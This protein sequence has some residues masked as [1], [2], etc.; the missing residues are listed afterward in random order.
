M[1]ASDFLV[2]LAELTR[3][4]ILNCVA[5]APLFVSDLVAILQL[6][7]PTVSRHLKVLR[8]LEVVHDMPLPPFVLYTFVL[9]PGSR[10]RLLRAVLE[11]VR[12]DPGAKAERAA[13]LQRTRLRG[14]AADAS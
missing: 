6:P 5:A 3:L 12:S 13:A 11:A 8:D 4:R 7:Q 2:A 1:S 10:G 9:H 14:A